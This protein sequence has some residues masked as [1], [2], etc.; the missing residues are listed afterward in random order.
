VSAVLLVGYHAAD[1]CRSP[2]PSSPHF[3]PS[4]E[5]V[6]YVKL[7][8]TSRIREQRSVLSGLVSR[9][10]A[11]LTAAARACRR[12]G[13]PYH[14]Y[15]NSSPLHSS[16]VA[17]VYENRSS[18]PGEN[19]PGKDHL[20]VNQIQMLSTIITG[21]PCRNMTASPLLLSTTCGASTTE[22]RLSRRRP[23]RRAFGS[24]ESARRLCWITNELLLRRTA[25]HM[26]TQAYGGRHDRPHSDRLSTGGSAQS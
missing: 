19:G 17:V 26:R 23:A 5:H 7:M 4:G 9:S 13:L 14:Q 16:G 11:R 1:G 8:M 25:S 20:E 10:L 2:A 6:A 21:D 24:L 3:P 22:G 18:P 12:R 15:C